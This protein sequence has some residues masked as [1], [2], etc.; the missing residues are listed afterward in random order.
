MRV[1]CLTIS[2]LP[3]VAAVCVALALTGCGG[4]PPARAIGEAYAGPATLRIRQDIDPRSAEAATVRHGDRLEILGRRRR[5]VKVRTEKGAE[6]WTHIR[7]LLSTAQMAALD[8]LAERAQKLPSQGAASV[9]EPLNVHTEPNRQAPSFYQM[10]PKD[11]VDVVEHKLSPRVPFENRSLLRRPAPPKPKP[12]KRESARKIPPPPRPPAPKPPANWMELSQ[13]E[14][15]EAEETEPPP[16]P[17]PMDDW[18]LVRLP[19]GRAGWALAWMLRMDIPDEVAQYSEGAHIT[20]Y[21]AMGEV[22]DGKQV[23][24]HWLW[25]TLESSRQPYQF[26]SFRYF[27]WNVRRHRYETAYIERNLRGYYPVD[28][29]TVNMKGQVTPAFSVITEDEDGV[30]WRKTYTYQIYRVTLIEK[31]R[32]EPPTDEEEPPPAELAEASGEDEPAGWWGRAKTAMSGWKQRVF[33]K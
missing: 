30:K 22:K 25:T 8:R 7:Q 23:K 29:H 2:G 5:F 28:V 20:A 17:V 12:R 31:A 27:I 10:K 11:L 21:F 24:R 13:A 3:S 33:G 18:A 6:G 4:E 14:P 15:E 16:K 1:Q 19:N 32:W 26:D 9:Y